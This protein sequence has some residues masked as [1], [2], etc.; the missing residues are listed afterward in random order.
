MKWDFKPREGL[1]FVADFSDAKPQIRQIPYWEVESVWSEVSPMIQKA[2]DVQDEWTLEGVKQ[3]LMVA[4]SNSQ[5]WMVGKSGAIVTIINRYQTG[6]NKC[7]LFLGGGDNL[8][9]SLHTHAEIEAWAKKWH[10]CH[11]M[12]IHGRKGWLKVLTGYKEV[13]TCMEKTL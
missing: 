2:I 10:G 8:E 1:V 5:L 3:S 4:N 12:I 9:N 11:K 13:T 7:L 6:I